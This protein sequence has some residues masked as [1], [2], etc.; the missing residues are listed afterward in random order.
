MCVGSSR[1][2]RLYGTIAGSLP[3]IKH[4]LMSNVI[5]PCYE[6]V[7]VGAE[8]VVL[9]RHASTALAGRHGT[10]VCMGLGEPH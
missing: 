6:A 7:V 1:G 3:R 2:L 4:E 8:G 10:T 5:E 9:N